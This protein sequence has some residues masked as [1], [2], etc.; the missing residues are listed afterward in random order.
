MGGPERAARRRIDRFVENHPGWNLR[1][2]R[3]PAGFR[4]LV[5]HQTFEPSDPVVAGFFQ[6]LR[7][8]P[9]YARMCLNQQCFRARVSAKP[10]RIGVRAHMRPRPGVWP[11]SAEQMPKRNAWIESYETAAR[12]YAACEFVE[13]LGSGITHPEVRRVQELHD[14]LCS[15]TRSLPIA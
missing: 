4:V 13:V 10:W 3:T 14:E 11:V 2:Y 5:T 15:A 6:A 1:V 12:K 8:D 7:V 9:V